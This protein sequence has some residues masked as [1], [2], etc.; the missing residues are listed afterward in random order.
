MAIQNDLP[1]YYRATNPGG[2]NE[3][4][5]SKLYQWDETTNRPVEVAAGKAKMTPR[6]G[7]DEWILWTDTTTLGYDDRTE[8]PIYFSD[9]G[10]GNDKRLQIINHARNRMGLSLLGNITD[11]ITWATNEAKVY[12]TTNISIVNTDSED[13]IADNPV[14]IPTD[15]ANYTGDFWTP[16]GGGT[17]T[18]N[19]S[20][21]YKLDIGPNTERFHNGL[22]R[23]Y[24]G[25][26]NGAMSFHY[27][28]K[29]WQYAPTNSSI[30]P[31]YQGTRGS[32]TL[33]PKAIFN[34]DYSTA[35]QPR[36]WT[37]W[38]G[39]TGGYAN[40]PAFVNLG[41]VSGGEMGRSITMDFGGKD[42]NGNDKSAQLLSIGIGDI[43]KI[44]THLDGIKYF[45]C[46]NDIE[47]HVISA[48]YGGGDNFDEAYT[49]YRLTGLI[50]ISPMSGNANPLPVR[51]GNDMTIS[52][53]HDSQISALTDWIAK[54]DAFRAKY[55]NLLS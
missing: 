54:Y 41:G 18:A 52:V 20:L 3:Q 38:G 28:N 24:V 8:A 23:G 16:S 17:F 7:T 12:I 48:T 4:L 55:P 1:F 45:L 11:G 31:L 33:D 2:P 19:F 37:V 5:T 21:N 39:G 32:E 10:Q 53:M 50:A 51:S 35:Q 14:T 15:Y 42:V 13:Y 29:N 30:S 6:T 22:R 9:G 47:T 26:E 36:T 25:T 40:P 34:Y 43:V 49:L 44:Q 27:W 46:T